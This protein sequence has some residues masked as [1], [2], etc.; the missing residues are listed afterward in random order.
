MIKN[1]VNK[2]INR[3]GI[4]RGE[5]H[6]NDRDGMLYRAWSQVIWEEIEG[7]YVEFGVYKGARLM[8][9]KKI[10]AN[11]RKQIQNQIRRQ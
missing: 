11:L 5:I 1:V 3:L 8:Q 7:D 6:K 4:L 2:V 10:Y 9:S